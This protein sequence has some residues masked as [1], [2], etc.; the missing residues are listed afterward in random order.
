MVAEVRIQGNRQLR[1]EEV[2]QHIHTRRGRPFS[3]QVVEDDVRRLNETG[4]FVNIVPSWRETKN[5]RLVVFELIERR[6]MYYVLYTGNEKIHKFTLSKESGIEAGDPMSQ[7]TINE[8]KRKVEEYYRGKGYGNVH[9]TVLEGYGE[10]DRG[11]IF[12]IDE[13]TQQRV[14]RIVFEGNEIAWD[15][16]L[17]T[18]IETEEPFAA[19]VHRGL[20]PGLFGA[21]LDYNKLEEDVHRLE[22]YYRTL[23]YFRCK[24]GRRI[25]PSPFYGDVNDQPF[26]DEE[27]VTVRFI[28]D[29]GPRFT[30]GEIRVVGAQQF[31][32]DALE[33]E[34]ALKEGDF[35]NQNT[36]A[37]DRGEIVDRYGEI[38]YA[39]AQITAEPVLE[40]KRQRGVLDLVY[41]IEEGKKH[42]VGKINVD[43]QGDSPHSKI[44]N[45]LNRLS[46]VPGDV[47]N[48]TEMRDSTRRLRG[49]GIFEA[50]PAL[51]QMPE[52]AIRDPQGEKTTEVAN[53][54]DSADNGFRGQSPHASVAQAYPPQYRPTPSTAT[55]S[56]AQRPAPHVPQSATSRPAP[57]PS[58]SYSAVRAVKQPMP[59]AT[60]EPNPW[61]R[62]PSTPASDVWS[63]PPEQQQPSGSQSPEPI[64]IRG[65]YGGSEAFTVP[66]LSPSTPNVMRGQTPT[67]YPS[68]DSHTPSYGSSYSFNAPSTTTAPAVPSNPTPAVGSDMSGLGGYSAPSNSGYV[69]PPIGA[70]AYQPGAYQPGTT[71][72]GYASPTV[73]P[74]VNTTSYGTQ[75]AMS[76]DATASAYSGYSPPQTAMAPQ[77][78]PG[79]S[80]LF[81]PPG[82]KLPFASPNYEGA[83]T[84]APNNS[85]LDE[86]GFLNDRP[87]GADPLVP[88]PLYPSVAETQTGQFMLSV[89]LSSDAGLMGNILLSERNFNIWRLPRALTW[90]D[91]KDAFRGGDQ[92]L[93]IEASPG[94]EVQRYSIAFTD[95][96]LFDLN[97]SMSLS[98]SYYTRY[99]YEWH[100]QRLG[101]TVSFGTQWDE[102]SKD[103]STSFTFRAEEVEI[104]QPIVPTPS[105][106]QDALGK[107]SLFG[108]GLNVRYDKRDH[109]FMPTEGHFFAAGV[110]QVLGTYEYTRGNIDL[111]KYFTLTRRPDYSGAHVLGLRASMGVTGSNTPIYEHFF[112]GGS[113]TIRGFKYRE[114]S[115]RE[116][117]VIVGG[118]F[119]LLTSAEY[120]FPITQTD[121]LRGVIFCDAGTVEPTIDD[122]SD[123]MRVSP[124]FGLRISVPFMGQAPIALDFAFPA[125]L[126]SGDAVNNFSFSMGLMR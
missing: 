85:I 70:G 100:E 72:T 42:S 99:Y 123:S 55:S 59:T 8:A 14:R 17:K 27:W 91:L 98:G 31:D 81:A 84:L 97:Y 16:R 114:A 96:Y 108:F 22:N 126:E 4:M 88:V 26:W 29:E 6:I 78:S 41:R 48:L 121:S 15:D 11:V 112:A 21:E 43:I 28:I 58:I 94:T 54:P 115:P 37:I 122:W 82:D 77:G 19:K 18:Q 2:L 47:L 40:P 73:A 44:T 66:R 10:N 107:S 83:T 93:R 120:M 106:L 56:H 35:Y 13:G 74:P 9:V 64:V 105:A 79:I 110:E 104:Y 50:N 113:N 36:L 5:G 51:G 20:L 39:F 69:P 60:P 117:G 62:R 53:R 111:R 57:P 124:G 89:G 67:S 71:T 7:Y 49:A 46:L 25:E 52:I 87:P 3:Q 30:I 118:E 38:G 86:S 32:P 33:A 63:R 76:S 101:G 68:S 80:P 1:N 90:Y 125:L 95:P 103:L 12:Q 61:A 65:Q 109:P 75:P 45:V 116:N 34:M 24:V 119:Q 92:I 23:G 102:I